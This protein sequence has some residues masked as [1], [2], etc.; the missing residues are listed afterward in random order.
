MT[1]FEQYSLI[2]NIV[3][4]LS[5]VATAIYAVFQFRRSA[6]IHKQ[7]LEWNKRIETRKKL[8]DYN[9]F[10]STI[11]LN[12][13]FRYIGKKHSIEFNVIEEQINKD[14][15]VVVHLNRLLNY[16]EALANGVDN[17]IYDEHLIRSSRRGAMIRTYTAFK[18]YIEHDRREEGSTKAWS[19]FETL[20]TTW[21][22]E[23][24]KQEG[25]PELG[26]V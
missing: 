15:E 9:R 16:Y 13:K 7:N 23:D 14:L 5:I 11:F 8:D 21:V 19:C 10:D 24:R 25:L 22:N 12:E 4:T 3:S 26:K 20:I 2:I 17:H 6:S 1:E 18:E